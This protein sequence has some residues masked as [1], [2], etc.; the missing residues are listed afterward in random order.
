[1]TILAPLWILQ[2]VVL[3]AVMA[4]RALDTLAPPT[5]LTGEMWTAVLTFRWNFWMTDNM[6]AIP[7]ELLGLAL[8]SI[9]AQLVVLVAVVVVVLP[10]RWNHVVL[11]CA[12]VASAAVVVALRVRVVEVQDPYVLLLDTFARS[13]AVF[14][15][16][17]AAC[18]VRAGCRVGPAASNAALV[19]LVG[20]VLAS[21]FVSPEQHLALQLPV[22][23]LLGSTALLDPG[24]NAGDWILERAMRSRAVG[25]LAP[26][27]APVL[28]CTT[29][30]AVIIGRRTEMHW[31]LRVIVLLIVLAVV[32]R[33]AGAVAGRIRLPPQP[34]GIASLMD[35]WRR[36][37]AEADAEVRDGPRA[38]ASHAAH[39]KSGG[40]GA[41]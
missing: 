34:I 13:D 9:V 31:I 14:L 39:D 23:A 1:M 26:I 29:P 18:A 22:T 30:A 24:V 17:A 8:L 15:G 37:V 3:V 41:G 19:V 25:V 40:P 7:A 16:V 28:V 32:V 6:L 21:G 5:T 12:A 35:A 11:G 20:A 27:W 36:V 38:R 33:V 4:A 10:G 2:V